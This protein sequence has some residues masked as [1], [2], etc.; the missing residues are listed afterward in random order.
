[1]M[2]EHSQKISAPVQGANKAAAVIADL[3]AQADIRVN[4]DAPWDIRVHSPDFYRRVLSRGSLGLGEAYMDGVWDVPR[5]DQ[6]FDRVLRAGLDRKLGGWQRV[7]VFGATL[8]NLLS[9]RQS[10][11]RSFQVG[12]Q[13][14]D[15]GNDVFAAM[16]DPG[17]NY[18]CAYWAKAE[19]LAE[20]QRHKL[21]LICR[22]LDLQ[23]GER[24]LEIGCGW[25][26]LARHAAQ[27]YGVEVFGV[28]VSREQLRLARERCAGLP[29][30]LALMDYRDI[31]GNFSKAV[32]VGMFEHVGKKNYGV[33]F[34]TVR[35][36]LSA[37]GLL[38]LHTIGTCGSA[39]YT[40]PWIDRYI[41]PNGMLPTARDLTEAIEGRLL[42]E[43][44]HSFGQDYDLTL[45]AW[46][47]SFERA[48]A[49]LRE[50]YDQRFYR[51]WTYYLLG[52]A[53]FFRSRQGQ[54]WQLVL[55]MP[56]RKGGYR[57]LR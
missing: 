43:D 29:V 2:P 7:R 35:N 20:A 38:L 12:V 23:P 39:G 51:M 10:Y 53:G 19:N 14:Y 5:L 24:L 42:I 30:E 40:D 45:M 26:G 1:M 34:D 56:E 15:I 54:L 16:L 22:K 21:D 47:E 52:S 17:M 44:W 33:F 25:G 4:G 27:H 48:W 18:S 28:T 50:H 57:S 37:E 13:H 49:Q 55:S 32:S 9:N 31:R 11:T 36:V 3:L 8:R 6:F 46:R 41:F